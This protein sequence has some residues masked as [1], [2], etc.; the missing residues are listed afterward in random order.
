MT[1][2]P[3]SP[4]GQCAH[5]LRRTEMH[6]AVI[7]GGGVPNPVSG[8]GALTAYTI[9]RELLE[10]GHRVTVFVLHDPVY[11]DPADAS[12]ASRS[13]HLCELGAEVVL[14][15]SGAVSAVDS[16]P[17]DL[18]FRLRRALSP[19]TADLNPHVVDAER[20]AAAVAEAGCEVA[21]VYHFE[22]LAASR[23]LGIPRVAGVGDPTHLPVYY[24][25]RDSFPSRAAVRRSLHVQ[26]HLR[27]QPRLLATLLEECASYGAFAAH[28]AEWFRSHGAP[29]C[30]YYRTPMPDLAGPGPNTSR[31]RQPGEP[32]RILLLG[33]LRGIVTVDGFRV[34]ARALPILDRTLGPGR[35]LIDVVGGYEPPPGL[36]ALFDNPSI[37]RHRHSDHVEEWLQ[38]TDV[39][40][41]PTSIPLGVRVRII[42]AFS[43]GTPIVTH[44]ANALGIPELEDGANA[45]VAASPE[46]IAEGIL[47]IARDDAL[48]QRLRVGARDTYERFF[49]PSVAAQAIVERIDRA[50][51]QATVS[52]VDQ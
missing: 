31:V 8:G 38:S 49:Q 7:T 50:A 39:L 23:E 42:A 44:K 41:V 15:P 13:D 34:F 37:R 1:S 19:R 9:V 52:T 20:L 29:R 17:R 21:F 24:R 12:M 22:A 14:I 16:A 11:Y 35:F 51:A 26:A 40:V 47:R 27:G 46:E 43:A 33:H 36:A 18:R 5:L 32:F 30:E 4:K 28:H 6:A 25:W 48:A 3:G 45:L 2:S 10:T